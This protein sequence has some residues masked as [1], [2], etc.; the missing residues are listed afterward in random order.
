MIWLVLKRTIK[1]LSV[2]LS[3]YIAMINEVVSYIVA[4][5]NQA[6]KAQ[7]LIDEDLVVISSLSEQSSLVTENRIV[8]TLINIERESFPAKS[9]QVP[10]VHQDQ[11]VSKTYR[12][13]NL[14]LY[15]M[16]VANFH[17]DKYQ[18]GL[19]LISHTID[20][21]QRNPVFDRHSHVSMPAKVGKLLLEIE[22]LSI[23]ELQSVWTLMTGQYMPSILFKVRTISFDQG[24]Q[25]Y[26]PTA[27]SLELSATKDTDK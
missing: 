19:R 8:A 6:L 11:R 1:N 21:F 18:E 12:P 26:E 4:Q 27:K 7:F 9:N 14:N 15:L 3:E 2:K 25:G 22:N 5:L 13:I 17:G 10:Y 23:R 16:F 24:V 20:F